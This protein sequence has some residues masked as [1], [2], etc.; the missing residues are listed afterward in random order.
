M[1]TTPA[2]EPIVWATPA[3]V[4]ASHPL[5]TLRLYM[6]RDGLSIVSLA[7]QQR[8]QSAWR[9]LYSKQSGTCMYYIGLILRL[10]R[11]NVYNGRY[12]LSSLIDSKFLS[13]KCG[14]QTANSYA[15]PQKIL[16]CENIMS[17]QR[18]ATSSNDE[19]ICRSKA[20]ATCVSELSSIISVC[21][22]LKTR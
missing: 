14:Q 3:L 18:C 20:A 12:P 2:W 5:F 17:H 15:F 4:V 8:L 7:S 1:D 21:D 22:I 9:L 16:I 10:I 13:I 19:T 6:T 11:E